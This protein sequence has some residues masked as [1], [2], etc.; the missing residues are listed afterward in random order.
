M[1]RVQGWMER[2]EQVDVEPYVPPMPMAMEVMEQLVEPY[3]P[4]MVDV[5]LFQPP[6]PR[7]GPHQDVAPNRSDAAKA[8]LREEFFYYNEQRHSR[9]NA[10]L[11]K[12]AIKE[13][14]QWLE[15]IDPEKIEDHPDLITE[16]QLDKYNCKICLGPLKE[17]QDQKDNRLIVLHCCDYIYHSPCILHH[18]LN[19]AQACPKCCD[20]KLSKAEPLTWTRNPLSQ[21]LSGEALAT[22]DEE[23]E[24]EDLD[25]PLPP[26]TE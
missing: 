4:Q 13:S 11:T 2:V 8:Q 21:P 22:T 15:A 25:I 7:Y 5:Q 26:G 20:S 3:V 18:L 19:F 10:W 17:P 1:E 16:H 23:S 9:F 24:D 12:E 6:Q 14:D